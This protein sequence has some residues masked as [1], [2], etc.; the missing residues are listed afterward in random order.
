ME[1]SFD[2]PTGDSFSAQKSSCF[3]KILIFDLHSAYFTIFI[4]PIVNFD[5]ICYT[6]VNWGDFDFRFLGF[7]EVGLVVS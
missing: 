4:E 6:E 2:F 7:S 5:D 3:L 1:K